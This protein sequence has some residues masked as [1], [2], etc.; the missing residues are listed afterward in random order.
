MILGQ[1]YRAKIEILRSSQNDKARVSEQQSAAT[2]IASSAQRS[3]DILFLS[4]FARFLP[5]VEMTQGERFSH[6][7]LFRPSHDNHL[8]WRNCLASLVG[9]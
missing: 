5:S 4:A 6:Y 2:A 3:R 7:N 8:D 9:K 1:V